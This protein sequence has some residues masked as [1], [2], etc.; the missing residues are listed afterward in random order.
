MCDLILKYSPQLIKKMAVVKH[1][2]ATAELLSTIID[3]SIANHTKNSLIMV[4][5]IY[6]I[7]HIT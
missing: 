3:V 5:V 6:N 1:V 4:S 2:T 7:V